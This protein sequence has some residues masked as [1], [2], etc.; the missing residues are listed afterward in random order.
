MELEKSLETI[1]KAVSDLPAV[2]GELDNLK[3][4]LETMKAV[5]I[6]TE[7]TREKSEFERKKAFWKGVVT[8]SINEYTAGEGGYLVPEEWANDIL[9]Y[10]PS[11]GIVRPMATV[12][13]MTSDTLNVQD[14]DAI[15]VGY[16]SG[17]ASIGE[18]N[19]TAS[20][21]AL[22][23]KNVGAILRFDNNFLDDVTPAKIRFIEE[24][25]MRAFGKW[26][27]NAFLKGTGALDATNGG[28]TGVMNT[29]NVS[30]HTMT[31]TA[32]SGIGVDDLSAMIDLATGSLTN[33]VFI[34][35]KTIRS[36]VRKLND[37]GSNIIWT[38]AGNGD[39]ER[40]WGYPVYWTPTGVMPA[41]SA[42]ATGT[43]FGIFGDF[44]GLLIGDRGTIQV[45]T[46]TDAGF[47]TNQTLIRMMRRIDAKTVAKQ[48]AIIKTATGS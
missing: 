6:I 32:F 33:P 46:S 1:E 27:D 14:I 8:K 44:R 17:S 10:N 41:S 47:T 4:E 30:A 16:V 15:S 29:A 21:Y 3:K 23:L 7:G 24:N 38:P 40:I 9:N 45:A 12:L 43:S 2:K 11:F 35:D 25:A 20:N 37:G 36:Y 28:I 5:S 31:S 34:F 39:V 22:S 19:L 48:F 26:E 13:P 42:S 18:Q